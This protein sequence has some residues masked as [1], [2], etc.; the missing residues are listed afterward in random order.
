M[1]LQIG[2]NARMALVTVRE[3]KVRSAL[4]VFGVVI[5]I[6]TVIV[7][8]SIL[9]GLSRNIEESLNDFGPNTLFVFKF[10]PGVHFG[11]LSTEERMRK[12]LSYEDEQAIATL[13]AVKKASAQCF[14]RIGVPQPP[15]PPA[16]YQ[17]RETDLNFSGVTPS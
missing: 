9:V 6:L 7:V 1:R 11:R 13:P 4:T 12:S 17:G 14:P 16:R 2:E 3:N 15:Q 5:G 10:A 8:S